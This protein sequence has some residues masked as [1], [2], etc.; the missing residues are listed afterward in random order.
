MN[1]NDRKPT[2]KAGGNVIYSVGSWRLGDDGSVHRRGRLKYPTG[3]VYDGE[4]IDGKRHGQGLLTFAG[5]G[6]YT[7]EFAHNLFE[8][9]GVLR[10]PKSQHP[11]TKLWMRGEKFEGEFV[12]G[13]KHGR[14]T[15]QTR[16]GDQYDGEFKQGLYGGRGVCVYGGSG[17][18]YD[19]EFMANVMGKECEF[20]GAVKPI[21]RTGD[22]MKVHGK[23][24]NLMELVCSNA[25]AVLQWGDL[26][27]V[28][29]LA[30]G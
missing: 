2:V 16:G 30:R 29:K 19:G 18:V 5:G 14:G 7:G 13:L 6:S 4:W 21:I 26:K 10:I 3:D 27:M 24:T 23:A 25:T 9:F 28:I 8:G 17:D 20:T 15:W 12:C 1:S 11:L 22:D